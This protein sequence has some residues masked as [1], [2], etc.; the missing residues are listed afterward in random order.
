M[1]NIM[2]RNLVEQELPT[3][4][5]HQSSPPVFSGAGTAYP[6][7]APEFTPGV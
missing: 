5:E 3:L 1:V 7:G 4:L 6:S 2:K